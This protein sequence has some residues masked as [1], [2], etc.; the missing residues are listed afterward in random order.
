MSDNTPSRLLDM[1]HVPEM[2]IW[3]GLFGSVLAAIVA[4]CTMCAWNTECHYKAVESVARSG[5]TVQ[6]IQEYLEARKE[7][8]KP[9]EKVCTDAIRIKDGNTVVIKRGHTLT[10]EVE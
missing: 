5:L 1:K 9:A 10:V 4:A 7:V 2:F 6:Q 3:L 8:T